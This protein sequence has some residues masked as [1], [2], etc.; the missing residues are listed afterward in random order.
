M[1]AT[2]LP[3]ILS[4]KRGRGRPKMAGRGEGIMVRFHHNGLPDQVDTWIAEQERRAV[5]TGSHPAAARE[6]SRKGKT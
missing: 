2:A 4:R 3:L 5:E 1:I 6:G